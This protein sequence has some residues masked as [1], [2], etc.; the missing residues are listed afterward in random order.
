MLQ[1]R[2]KTRIVDED[3]YTAKGC[4]VLDALSLR[5][6]VEVEDHTCGTLS[7]YLCLEGIETLCAAT[8]DDDLGV[9][10]CK[11]EGCGATNA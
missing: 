8:S 11:F 6:Y 3:I 5:A 7:L 4:E 9:G 1:T 2:C 10:T